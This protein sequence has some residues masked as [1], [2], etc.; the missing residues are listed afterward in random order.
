MAVHCSCAPDDGCKYH[1]KH[2]ELKILQKRNKAYSTS[3]WNLIKA[4]VT[5]M[6]ETTNIKSVVTSVVIAV[7]I[8]VLISRTEFHCFI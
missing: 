5:K 3:S 8:S 4:Y 1:P 6:Y 2:I 7:A